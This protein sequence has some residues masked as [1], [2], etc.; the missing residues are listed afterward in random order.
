MTHDGR[1]NATSAHYQMCSSAPD[2]AIQTT[3][4]HS[5]HQQ[6]LYS[7]RCCLL[8]MHLQSGS[9][10]AAGWACPSQ[11]QA[12]RGMGSQH[13]GRHLPG[14][15]AHKQNASAVTAI[16]HVS[17]TPELMPTSM[18]VCGRGSDCCCMILR[19][20]SATNMSYF[21][22]TPAKASHTTVTNSLHSC[23]TGIRHTLRHL[24]CHKMTVGSP[25]SP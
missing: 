19:P 22:I 4:A 23:K 24:R 15:T 25:A 10:R 18:C 11:K 7:A 13:S 16:K 6:Q 2:H 12:G 8:L 1:Q 3:T 17:S 14:C 9:L 21:P 20:P 5:H